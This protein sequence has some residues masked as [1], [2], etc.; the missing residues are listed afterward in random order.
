MQRQ[1][2]IPLLSVLVCDI[3][4]I[5]FTYRAKE[6]SSLRQVGQGGPNLLN[7]IKEDNREYVVLSVIGRDRPGIVASVSQVLNTDEGNVG[8]NAA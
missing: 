3:V 7:E 2:R 5:V 1:F 6:R 8:S 4:L